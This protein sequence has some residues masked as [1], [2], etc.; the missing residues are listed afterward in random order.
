MIS[1]KIEK[2]SY[3]DFIPHLVIGTEEQRKEIR[4]YI[5]RFGVTSFMRKT[6]IWSEGQTGL[7]ESQIQTLQWKTIPTLIRLL[8]K[9]K[10]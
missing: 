6:D 3:T 1:D 7:K 10:R 8:L 2:F 4:E 9:K 5:E